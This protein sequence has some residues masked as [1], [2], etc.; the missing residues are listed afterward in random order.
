MDLKN[1]DTRLVIVCALC[2]SLL[3]GVNCFT[4][5]TDRGVMTLAQYGVP[6]GEMA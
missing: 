3:S 1:V 6:I 5:H 2:N 4:C